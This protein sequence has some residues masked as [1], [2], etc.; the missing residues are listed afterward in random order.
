VLLGLLS[1][2]NVGEFVMVQ[3]ALRGPR[4]GKAPA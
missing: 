1:T 4:A 3:A 2:E